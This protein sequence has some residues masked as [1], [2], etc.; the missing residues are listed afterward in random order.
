MNSNIFQ[1]FRPLGKEGDEV[2]GLGSRRIG[3]NLGYADAWV[4]GIESLRMVTS[5]F[6]GISLEVFRRYVDD[7][8]ERSN[9]RQGWVSLAQLFE[10][11]GGGCGRTKKGFDP[12]LEWLVC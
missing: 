5:C 11:R 12:F 9:M 1:R 7:I 10:W 2:H 8:N 6:D 3:I 4:G